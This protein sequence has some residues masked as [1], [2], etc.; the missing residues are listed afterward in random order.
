[1]PG[2]LFIGV[3]DIVGS[4]VCSNSM[5]ATEKLIY[6]KIQSS[7]HAQVIRKTVFF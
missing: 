3:A 4:P 5:G 7:I 6:L 1:M 2:M